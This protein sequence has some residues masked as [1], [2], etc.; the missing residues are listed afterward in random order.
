M[1]LK[2]LNSLVFVL[3][4]VTL[5]PGLLKNRIE[6]SIHLLT[7][8]VQFLSKWTLFS[9]SE[10]GQES[11][12]SASLRRKEKKLCH[13]NTTITWNLWEPWKFYKFLDHLCWQYQ[14]DNTAENVA[15]SKPSL[16]TPQLKWLEEA[17]SACRMSYPFLSA[18]LVWRAEGG[19]GEHEARSAVKNKQGLHGWKQQPQASKKRGVQDVTGEP[20]ATQHSERRAKHSVKQV[21]EGD[22][23][24]QLVQLNSATRPE[25][26]VI[27]PSPVRVLM[28]EYMTGLR[29]YLGKTV[30]ERCFLFPC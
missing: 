5:L 16:L 12:L 30:A 25:G 23:L 14:H 17:K 15:P 13:L 18:C 10:A 28:A 19:E 7:P 11:F 21:S 1:Q 27:S 29:P 3:I 24:P 2:F 4:E 8:L 20:E 6:T 9:L 22:S 26:E